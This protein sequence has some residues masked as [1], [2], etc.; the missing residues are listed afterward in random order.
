MNETPPGIEKRTFTSA[1]SSGRQST[2]DFVAIEEPLQ[3]MVDGVPVAVLMRSP[4]DEKELAA[5]FCISEGIIERLDDI[6][7]VRHCGSS[8]GRQNVES[9]DLGESR[10]VVNIMTLRQEA[11][12]DDPRRD[13][14]RLIR[15]GCGRS[16]AS[17]LAVTLKPVET[18]ICVPQSVIAGLSRTLI[19]SQKAYRQSGGI[20]AVAIFDLAGKLVAMGE[21]IGRH[22][23]IDKAIGRCLMRRIPLNDKI[24]YS[25]G[26]ASYE[27]VVKAVR[28]GLP[29]VVSRSSATT[30]AIDLA[31]QLNCTLIGYARGERLTIYAHIER[32]TL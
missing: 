25:T 26:R 28:V 2:N 5:G 23:A 15:S 29:V 22:N 16:D 18:A 10:N 13:V 27:M 17:E 24:L 31:E 21:D 14:L 7:L 12:R 9:D 11:S 30:L 3:I 32:V 4:G 6:G 19:A 20:H 8:I 1:R